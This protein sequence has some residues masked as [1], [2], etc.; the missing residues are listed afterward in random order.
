MP[1]GPGGPR[2]PSFPFLP[3]LPLCPGSPVILNN[4]K[5][6]ISYDKPFV[7]K[8]I[9]KDSLQTSLIAFVLNI[10]KSY[11][12]DFICNNIILTDNI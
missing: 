8:K 1:A 2:G 7:I 9:I 4:Y 3:C 12:L 6:I 11:R 10:I 5:Y